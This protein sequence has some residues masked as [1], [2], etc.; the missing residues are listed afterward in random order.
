M[1]EIQLITADLIED[2]R[3]QA[4]LSPRRRM[5]HNFHASM[6]ENPHRLLNVLL[7]GTYVRPHRHL[8]PPKAESFVVLQGRARLF[9]FDDSGVVQLNQRLESG[10]PVFGID[11]APGVWHTILS[12]CDCAVIFEIKPGPWS[13]VTDKSF[14]PWAPPEGDPAVADY[15]ERL[16]AMPCE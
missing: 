6:E 15:L 14:A 11:L 13:P 7:R 12:D 16:L 5:N 4:G 8:D 2:V 3:R 9:V 1:P 10:G